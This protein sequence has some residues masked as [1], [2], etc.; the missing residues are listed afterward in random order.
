MLKIS[1]KTCALSSNGRVKPPLQLTCRMLDDFTLN[2]SYL[3]GFLVVISLSRYITLRGDP[4]V[5]S[6]SSY[7]R[8]S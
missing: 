6:S 7:L 3:A 1:F 4:M 5:R 8:Y 2:V